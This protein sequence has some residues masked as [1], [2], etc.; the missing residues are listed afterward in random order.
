MSNEATEKKET[1]PDFSVLVG[2][3]L[4]VS[5]TVDESMTAAHL[6]SGAVSVLATPI[7]ILLMEKAS[8]RS[9]ADALPEGYKSVGTE[10]NIKHTAATPVGMEVT[11]SATVESVTGSKIVFAV[12]ASDA[13]G[14]VG[15]GTHTR[16]VIN[17]AKFLAKAQQKG[18]K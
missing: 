1:R 15:R 8:A 17:E 9:I 13:N 16:Y 6:G 2:K 12:M 7:M 11:A 3:T 14:E 18:E 5:R 10:V 4:S